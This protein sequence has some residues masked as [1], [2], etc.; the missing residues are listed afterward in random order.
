M[1]M[2]D[3]QKIDQILGLVQGLV[4]DVSELK[5]DMKSLHEF[6]EDQAEAL[7]DFSTHVDG[8]FAEMKG[9]MSVMQG[10]IVETRDQMSLMQGQMNTRMVSKDYLDEKLDDLRVDLEMKI[11]KAGSED[12]VL[13]K[14]L[15]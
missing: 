15:R 10:Q 13:M 7:Q 12:S 1:Y 14:V 4:V 8:Q 5:S 11:R 6:V 2:D 9:Q 3:H